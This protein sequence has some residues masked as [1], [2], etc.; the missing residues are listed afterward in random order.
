MLALICGSGMLPVA[1]AG[2]Q[3]LPPLICALEG[4]EPDRLA[5]D[6][7][8]RLET[9]GTLLQQLTDRGVDEV[10]FCGAIKRPQIDP[11]KLDAATLPLVPIVMQNIGKGDDGAL[12]A[13]MA[14]FQDK[15]FAVRGAHEVAPSLL[16]SSGILTA[17][18]PAPQTEA[19]VRAALGALADMG[20]RDLGQAC[21]VRNGV[22]LAREDESGTDAL[23]RSVSAKSTSAQAED[24][25]FWAM[26]QAG[27]LL[28]NAADWLAGADNDRDDRAASEGIMF[29]AP[30]PGQ[31]RRADLPTIGPQTAL[32][33]AQAG[34]SGIV[35]E[36][37]GVMVL[38]QDATIKV[39][40][41]LNLFLWVRAP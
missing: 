13:L 27:E 40:D 28:E 37:G 19:D 38:E 2:A 34:L 39:M 22:V 35:I 36:A 1:I 16:P 4:F 21:V 15:G 31:D 26:D 33:V 24:P 18:Q 30:K 10:C 23:L 3:T 14:L 32:G 25:F 6:L 11:S 29:K 12:R 17:R 20:A 8:F 7:V 41:Q 9:L 5:P